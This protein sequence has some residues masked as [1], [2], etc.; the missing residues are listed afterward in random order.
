MCLGSPRTANRAA[1]LKRW[2]FAQCA[3]ACSDKTL[4][5]SACT[6]ADQLNE[7]AR[8]RRG[9]YGDQL[10]WPPAHHHIRPPAQQ[11]KKETDSWDERAALLECNDMSCTKPRPGHVLMALPVYTPGG[12]AIRG[13]GIEITEGTEG[14]ELS[15]LA[16]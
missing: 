13:T 10:N 11:R 6:W 1:L 3:L 9:V 15:P 16:V 5:R 2:G 14:A 12:G 7:P 4:T 8:R